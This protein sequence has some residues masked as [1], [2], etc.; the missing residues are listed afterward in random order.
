MG[1]ILK[2]LLIAGTGAIGTAL[3]DNFNMYDYTVTSRKLRKS[4][5]HY[6]DYIILDATNL[7]ELQ[8]ELKKKYDVIIDFLVYDSRTF[9]S[10]INSLL[11]S[12]AHYIFLS[13]SR[14]YS[15]EDYNISTR[16]KRLLDAEKKNEFE[17]YN[18]YALEKARQEDILFSSPRRNFTVI[19]PYITYY[20]NRLQFGPFEINSWLMG[21]IKY[22]TLVVYEGLLNRFTTLTAASDVGMIIHD[23]IANG[24]IGNVVNAASNKSIT[25][26]QVLNIYTSTISDK[27]NIDFNIVTISI[28][29]FVELFG[30]HDAIYFDRE[31]NRRF[32]VEEK[33]SGMFKSVDL[34]LN[35]YLSELLSTKIDLRQ[36]DC[37]YEKGLLTCINKSQLNVKIRFYLC[38]IYKKILEL[39]KG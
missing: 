5:K 31:Y 1:D 2:I 17:M 39:L 18:D 23:A 37:K 28:E 7:N 8:I 29:K 14:V 10:R 24:P 34:M 16:T 38:K 27:L 11:E 26:Q 25:W 6:V 9:G 36:I 15:N 20:K 12:T 22:K 21:I 30:H 3:L 35:D 19:R 13:S 33:Y 32:E 4:H